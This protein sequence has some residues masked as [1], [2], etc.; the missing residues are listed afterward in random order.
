MGARKI[1]WIQDRGSNSKMGKTTLMRNFKICTLRQLLLW[2]L[3][4][5]KGEMG[6]TCSTHQANE[7]FTH[8][9]KLEKL[10]DLG[11]EV[12]IILKCILEHSV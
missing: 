10:R 4:K 6:V 8:A 11:V 3:N 2:R 12:R 9:R 7:Q 1:I 5:K